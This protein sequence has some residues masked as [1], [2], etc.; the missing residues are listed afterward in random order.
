MSCR[1]LGT[2]LPSHRFAVRQ[3]VVLA[4]HGQ[5]SGPVLKGMQL[6]YKLLYI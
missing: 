3:R 6:M 2:T 5:R 1:E 4:R